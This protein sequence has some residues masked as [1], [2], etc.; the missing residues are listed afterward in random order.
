[1]ANA[2]RW[3]PSALEPPGCSTIREAVR[4]LCDRFPGRLLARAGAATRYPDEFVAA[5]TEPAGSRR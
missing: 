4:E 2:G 1:M 5:L 3:E